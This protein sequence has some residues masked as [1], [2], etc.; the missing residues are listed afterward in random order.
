MNKNDL[1]QVHQETKRSQFRQWKSGK[2]WLYSACALAILVGGGIVASQIPMHTQITAKADALSD[3]GAV[4]IGNAGG[5]PVVKTPNNNMASEKFSQIVQALVGNNTSSI[6]YVAN[7]LAWQS[8]TTIEGARPVP[9]VGIGYFMRQDGFEN[10]QAVKMDEGQSILI[11]NMGTVKDMSGVTIP[12]DVKLTLNAYNPIDNAS[13]TALPKTGL[14]V[15]LQ[16]LASDGTLQIDTGA[17]FEG[18]TGGGGQGET[19]GGGGSGSGGTGWWNTSGVAQLDKVTFS[20]TLINHA[21]GAELDNVLQA[22][23]YSDID[24][25]QRVSMGMLGLQGTILSSDT[26]ITLD[27]GVLVGPSTTTNETDGSILGVKSLIKVSTNTTN[28]VVY[29]GEN[30]KSTIALGAF[31]KTDLNIVLD[32][33]FKL[34]KSL[35]NYGDTMPNNL[36][37]FTPLV[38]DIYDKNN[39]DVGDMVIPA[40]GHAVES[41]KL[42][43]GDY[44]VKERANSVTSVT[45]QTHNTKEYKVTVIAGKTGNDAPVV[46]VDNKAVMGEITI[47]KTGVESGDKM[48]N[49]NYTLE[50]NEF[51]LTSLTDS[52]TYTGKTDKTG[53]VIFKNLPLGDYLPEETKASNGFVNTFKPVKVTLTWKDNKTEIVYGSTS[54]TNQE[55]KGEN[56]L[57]KLDKE[58]GTT[59]PQGKAE[60]KTA[61][62]AYFYNDTS[63]G[64]SPHKKGDPVKWSDIPNPKLISGEK[65]T[66]S[67]INGKVVN[68]GDNVVLRVDPDKLNV[69]VGNFP[70][71]SF[72]SQ[73]INAPVGYAPDNSKHEFELKKK[74]DSTQNIITPQSKS[75]EQVI[76]AKILIQKKVEISGESADSGYNDIKFNVTP[77]N[78]TKGD[79][80][81]ITTGIKDDEDGYASLEI[82]YGDYKLTED[83]KSAPEGYDLIK[84]IYIHME[85]DTKTDIITIS[86]SYHE[87]FSKPFSKRQFTQSDNQTDKNGNLTG[88]N[89]GSVTSAVPFISLSKL[90]FTDKDKPLPPETPSI[91]VEKS[92]EKIPQAGQGNN[93]DEPNNIGLG[94]A[95]T[96][97][98]AIKLDDKAKTVYFRSTNN[99]TE[100][101]VDIEPSDKTIIGNKLVKDIKYTYQG[102]ALTLNKNGILELDGKVFELPVD[103]YIEA[104]GTLE[105][106]ADGETHADEITVKAKGKYSGKTVSDKDK[107]YG[108]KE[109]TPETPL[110]KTDKPKAT[111]PM[112]GEQATQ[113]A[114]IIGSLIVAVIAFI[115]HKVI[116]EALASVKAKVKK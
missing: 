1:K 54:G 91:D 9:T 33:T 100:P 23:R 19:G 42:P 69:Y 83:E 26:Q 10:A 85:T 62:Y 12:I 24:S 50:G 103:G 59:T 70:L 77:I 86:A 13:N 28:A 48:W 64:S 68:H 99:G 38:F 49:E 72:Y 57:L 55:V 87:D 36:Y 29:D 66:Q 63:T 105:K 94:D 65:V 41:P 22:T 109:K 76:K 2:K 82:P 78:D 40:N 3:T 39:K 106:L 81:T 67:V 115:K 102:K 61:E 58:T 110:P 108:V 11:K 101:L 74:D 80:Q 32:G 96:K 97:E 90:V 51:K 25:G 79:E 6:K 75:L 35:L 93:L 46:K 31:G 71:G 53:K 47:I 7:N 8:N 18:A 52:K 45:G 17:P 95:D 34:D 112:T 98:T 4:T 111:L 113:L 44:T 37:S 92:S 15:A 20:Y 5:K 116:I 89:A 30:H 114:V 43:P 56:E 107:W 88:S 104:T 14:L 84:P 73:E 27:N 21:T 60:M 16:G